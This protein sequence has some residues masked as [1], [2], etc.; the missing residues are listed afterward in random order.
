M[1]GVSFLCFVGLNHDLNFNYLL[2]LICSKNI[3][4]L[5]EVTRDDLVNRAGVKS[6]V[7]KSVVIPIDRNS[8]LFAFSARRLA[9][10]SKYDDPAVASSARR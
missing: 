1:L 9:A 4:I 7:L 5:E 3:V 2:E 8:V 10:A 6:S